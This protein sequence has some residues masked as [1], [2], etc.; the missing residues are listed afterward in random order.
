MSI[1][2]HLFVL[3]L[4]GLGIIIL[5]QLMLS[6]IGWLAPFHHPFHDKL[7]LW[8]IVT[9]TKG[10]ASV[11]IFDAFNQ[12]GLTLTHAFVIVLMAILF[13]SVVGLLVSA[14]P[15]SQRIIAPV[16]DFF[17]GVPVSIIYPIAAIAFYRGSDFFVIFIGAIPCGA[18]MVFAV[19]DGLGRIKAER[20]A[21]YALNSEE[22]AGWLLFKNYKLP[23]MLPSVFSGLGVTAS[24][25]LVL[26]CVLEM[27]GLGSSGSAGRVIGEAADASGG[28]VSGESL[29]LILMLGLVSFGLSYVARAVEEGMERYRF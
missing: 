7:T 6:L 18:L 24:Y 2:R 1:T 9:I 25:A 19:L 17:R 15:K 4:Q 23:S 14:M 8:S 13:A 27:L 11:G 20:V 29:I 28:S 10:E 26:A 12:V 22:K 5:I 16:C 3:I 21:I